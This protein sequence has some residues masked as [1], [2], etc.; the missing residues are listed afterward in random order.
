MV[1]SRVCLCKCLTKLK[2]NWCT[3]TVFLMFNIWIF[4]LIRLKPANV[5]QKLIAKSNGL[6]LNILFAPV[7]TKIRNHA[8]I[9]AE[10][11]F[12][13]ILNMICRCTQQ[14]TWQI[15]YCSTFFISWVLIRNRCCSI[16]RWLFH[17]ST[18]CILS[19]ISN[20]SIISCKLRVRG[21]F[22]F[23]KWFQLKGK[24]I[25]LILVVVVLP[26]VPKMEHAKCQAHN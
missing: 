20:R 24:K 21:I 18:G 25:L 16:F 6:S 8:F 12:I 19:S 1:F 4:T 9:S 10:I 22:R 17:Y 2:D 15:I 14:R 11:C 3:D 7:T 26:S 5:A 13:A 23:V